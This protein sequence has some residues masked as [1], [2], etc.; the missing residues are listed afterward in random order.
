MKYNFSVQTLAVSQTTQTCDI[1]G[2]ALIRRSTIESHFTGVHVAVIRDIQWWS[3]VH[4]GRGARDND[5]IEIP[6][7]GGASQRVRGRST[8]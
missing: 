4:H 5:A 1:Q 2:S 7:V 6:C 8:G 3:G